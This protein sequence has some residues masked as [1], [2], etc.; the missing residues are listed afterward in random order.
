MESKV[1]FH[2]HLQPVI[3]SRVCMK[4][5]LFYCSLQYISLTKD[6]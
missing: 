3:G 2:M 4:R 6:M 1:V 5:G